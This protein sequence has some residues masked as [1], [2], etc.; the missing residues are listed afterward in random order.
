MQQNT[1]R[2]RFK[3]TFDLVKDFS[4]RCALNHELTR[5]VKIV[6]NHQRYRCCCSSRS[7]HQMMRLS[8]HATAC[9]Y[10]SFFPFF[11]NNNCFEQPLGFRLKLDG[12]KQAGYA[13]GQLTSFEPETITNKSNWLSERDWKSASLEDSRSSRI[14]TKLDWLRAF[15]VKWMHVSTSSQ[16]TSCEIRQTASENWS[17]H[18]W[19][20][21]FSS[22][23][24][25]F[26]V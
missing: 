17:G 14:T 20:C 19:L 21:Y 18:V 26:Q 7:V 23:D 5:D 2:R 13:Q 4:G 24:H 9:Q 16:L 25:K 12:G 6:P 1:E 10:E 22:R 8:K 11:S 15:P 3:K